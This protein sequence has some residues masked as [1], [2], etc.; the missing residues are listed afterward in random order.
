MRR[1]QN[2]TNS[3]LRDYIAVS[4]HMHFFSGVIRT[5]FKKSQVMGIWFL[6][7]RSLPSCKRPCKTCRAA[8]VRLQKFYGLKTKKPWWHVIFMNPFFGDLNIRRA[9]PTRKMVSCQVHR[10]F[11]ARE[12]NLN[13]NLVT[14]R[15]QNVAPCSCWKQ[16][17]GIFIVRA[18]AQ[19]IGDN[20]TCKSYH[21]DLCDSTPHFKPFP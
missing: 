5:L 16:P 2:W 15:E 13:R 11:S 7:I 4:Y 17:G 12:Q 1:N 20:S 8:G 3:F 18:R 6:R 14:M 9:V 10:Y 19:W 21:G